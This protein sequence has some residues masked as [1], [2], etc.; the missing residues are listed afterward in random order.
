LELENK[1]SLVTGAGQGIGEGIAKVL[2]SH[3]SKVMI[4]DLNGDS[5]NKV[6]KEINSLFPNSAEAF[7]ADLTDSNAIKS[8]I[9]A[10]L[11]TFTKLDCICNNAAASK[12]LG[13]V[14]NYSLDDV[15]ATLD[16][17]FTSLWKCLQVEIQT[18]KEQAIPASVVNISSNSAIRGYAFNSIYAATKAAVNNLTQSVAKEVARNGI[19]VNAVSPG[20]INTP[21]VRQYFEAEPKAKEMLEKSSLLR[22][23]GE[24]EEIGELVSFLLS[25]RSSFITG[26]IISAD[27][28]S[29]IN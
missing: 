14:E 4:V 20:T 8:M 3:G 16:L 25:D 17:T 2:A 6:A 28:G 21:G 23:I 19:R 22:R 5:A 10:T 27:G 9:Q 7:E 24:P 13:P 15:Q 12:G 1:V 11:S 29:S 26:Q 18:L